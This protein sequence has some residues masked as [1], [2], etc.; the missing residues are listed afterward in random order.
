MALYTYENHRTYAKLGANDKELVRND[1][2]DFPTISFPTVCSWIDKSTFISRI[3]VFES[4]ELVPP[5]LMEEEIHRLTVLSPGGRP[6]GVISVNFEFLDLE[7]TLITSFITD[8]IDCVGDPETGIGY[9]KSLLLWDMTFVLF[10]VFLN[11]YREIEYIQGLYEEHSLP[12]T[13]GTV[14]ENLS[15]VTLGLKFP[16]H[17]DRP[18]ALTNS[19]YAS[20][21]PRMDY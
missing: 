7:D 13:S 1:I 11:P 14:G 20:S 8:Y 5:I 3:K 15:N 9:H 6:A 2:W 21:R 16:D 19:L 4:G 17:R 12:R 10:N 18:I